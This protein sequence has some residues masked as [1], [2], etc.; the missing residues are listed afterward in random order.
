MRSRAAFTL[1]EL[2]VVIAIIAVLVALLLPALVGARRAAQRIQCSAN[3][4][5]IGVALATYHGAIGSFPPG[6]TTLTEG[7]CQGMG[8]VGG[9]P[10]KSGANWMISLLPYIGAQ[11]LFEQYDFSQFNEAPANDTV[12]RTPI[13]LYLCPSDVGTDSP[14]VPASGPGGKFALALPFMPG[15]YRA[16]SGRSDGIGFLDSAEFITYP[17]AWR[18]PLHTI[19]IRGFTTERVRDITDGTSKTLMVGEMTTTT[20]PAWRTLWSYAFAHY[21][22]SAATPQARVLIGDYDKC[23]AMGGKGNSQPCKRGWGSLHGG[24]LHFLLC[25]GTVQSLSTEIDP[26]LFASLATIAGSDQAPVPGTE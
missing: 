9:F 22:L 2:L 14:Q 23:S 8:G 18:G 13:A 6:N 21:S 20:N 5:Q 7:I 19:G 16:V 15:S 24:V 10:S 4:K 1:V 12:R 17:P 25:D 26:E 11:P 3:L